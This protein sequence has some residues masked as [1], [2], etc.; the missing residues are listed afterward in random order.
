V[1][2]QS[3]KKGLQCTILGLR[4]SDPFSI[5]EVS[6]ETEAGA[7]AEQLARDNRTHV[8]GRRKLRL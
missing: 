6:D 3:N 2:L 7:A 8:N 1:Q 5:F 4:F